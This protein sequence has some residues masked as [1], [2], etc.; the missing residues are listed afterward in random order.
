MTSAFVDFVEALAIDQQ[1]DA[2][3]PGVAYVDQNGV[4]RDG[5]FDD[6]V[7]VRVIACGEE[8][9]NQCEGDRERFQL[10]TCRRSMCW[11][12]IEPFRLA[13]VL[14]CQHFRGVYSLDNFQAKSLIVRFR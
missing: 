7:D 2:V 8:R 4:V 12:Y 11:L 14:I 9:T 6:G 1:L 3:R 10:A 5:I 13:D